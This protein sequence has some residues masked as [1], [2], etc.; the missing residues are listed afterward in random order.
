MIE[1]KTE[2]LA[3]LAACSSLDMFG[4]GNQISNGNQMSTSGTWNELSLI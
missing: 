3:K 2:L 1:L 4:D